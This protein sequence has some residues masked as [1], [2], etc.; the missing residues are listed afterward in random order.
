MSEKNKAISEAMHGE[1]FLWFLSHPK[2]LDR[3]IFEGE[4]IDLFSILVRYKTIKTCHCEVYVYQGQGYIKD[5]YEIICI[6][7]HRYRA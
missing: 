4:D 5:E 1:V 3:K 7:E 2:K 6:G